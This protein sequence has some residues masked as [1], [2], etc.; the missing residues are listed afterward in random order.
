MPEKLPIF[1]PG[2]VKSKRFTDVSEITKFPL[3][4]PTVPVV[5][6]VSEGVR[7]PNCEYTGVLLDHV[8][9]VLI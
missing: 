8:F 9:V 5:P 6:N 7:G 3:V 2:P 4:D 1:S